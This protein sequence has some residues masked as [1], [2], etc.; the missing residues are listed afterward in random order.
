MKE[1]QNYLMVTVSGQ[2][3]PGIAAAFTGILSE[4]HVEIMDIE[5]ASPQD[6]LGLYFLL[7]LSSATSKKD[8][9][10]KDLLF[11]AN[12]LGLNLQFKLYR[13]SEVQISNQRP[14]FVITHFGGTKALAALTRILGDENVNIE[15][16]TTIHNY[17]RRTMEMTVDVRTKENLTRIKKR[18]MIKSCELCFDMAVQKMEAYRKNK[19]LIV[20]D[21]DSTLVDMEIIDEIALRAGVKRE[22]SRVTEK[23]IRGD[24]DFEESLRQRV[25][26]LKGVSI[27]DLE[28]IR[29]KMALSKGVKELVRTLK[30]LGFKIGVVTGGFDFFSNHLKDKFGL[31]YAFANRLELKNGILT[32]RVIGDVIDAAGKARIINHL[33]QKE[34]ILLDQ[35]VA[36]GDGANDA[37]MLGQ[38]GLGIAYNAK[39]SLVN[40]ANMSIGK[41]RLTNILI[42]LGITEEDM[43]EALIIDREIHEA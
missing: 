24:L 29:Q 20:F 2:D 25:A 14:L 22:V 26:L 15:S 27:D 19:R 7:D 17:G 42:L 10:I 36:V 5:Q 12:Q 37:L 33:A 11:E 3:R 23:T 28:E 16:I 34:K 41:E 31:D 30:F 4:H 40:A 38:A 8:S 6:L 32:G 21:M 9:V 18:L 13:Q 1:E 43:Q 35:V 39:K